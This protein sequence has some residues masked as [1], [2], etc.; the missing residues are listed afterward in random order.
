MV[1]RFKF[2]FYFKELLFG[3]VR[4]AE[5]ADPDKYVYIG[6][7]TGFYSGSEF[8]LPDSSMG[9]NIIIFGVDMNSSVHIDNKKKYLNSWY[10]SNARIRLYS[11]S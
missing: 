5:N 3:G 9:R 6:Y 4:L 10:R 11:R 2:W 7:G 1:T 8:L